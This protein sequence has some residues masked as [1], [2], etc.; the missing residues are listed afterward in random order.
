MLCR[1]VVPLVI[2]VTLAWNSP[3]FCGETQA[4][5]QS[6][7]R[8]SSVEAISGYKFKVMVAKQKEEISGMYV[9]LSDGSNQPTS[10]SC[11]HKGRDA[12]KKKS[13]L[14]DD[15]A[16]RDTRVIGLTIGDTVW[17]MPHID[18]QSV[19]FYAYRSVAETNVSVFRQSISGCFISQ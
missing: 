17:V 1:A 9:V 16:I 14:V 11:S 15:C 19:S 3:A 12:Q 18:F 6:R 5:N 7:P 2:L 10:V 8:S 13:V 4:D